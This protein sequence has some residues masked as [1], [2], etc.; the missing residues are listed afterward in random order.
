[1]MAD[2]DAEARRKR[3]MRLRAQIAG[4]TGKPAETPEEAK[5]PPPVP[6]SPAAPASGTPASPRDF[7]ARR[8]REIEAD[9]PATEPPEDKPATE[10]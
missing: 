5:P 6:A 10:E 8:M 1:M 4:M 2:D 3:A 7:I 9:P